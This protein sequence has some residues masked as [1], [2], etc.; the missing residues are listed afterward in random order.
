[1]R[2]FSEPINRNAEKLIQYLIIVMVLLFIIKSTSVVLFNSFSFDGGMNAQ[3]AHNLIKGMNNTETYL[4]M[5]V[6]D[7]RIQTGFPVILPVA[8][9][10][11]VF[12]EKFSSGL[13]VNGVYLVLLL[14]ALIYYLKFCLQINSLF[15]FIIAV[16]FYATPSLFDFGF[17]LYGE[18][19]AL[20][21]FIL[22]II[23]IY[24]YYDTTNKSFAFFSGLFLGFA[25][26]TKTV[27]IIALPAFAL[28]ALIH[29]LFRKSIRANVFQKTGIFIFGF[30]LPIGILEFYKL[31]SL[32]NEA[33]TRWWKDMSS[34]IL[35]QAG[36][37]K[38]FTDTSG[39]VIK[40]LA[41]LDL[42]SSYIGINKWILF[43]GLSFLAISY[44]MI[45]AKVILTIKFSETSD[46]MSEPANYSF[47]ILM[48]TTLSYFGWWLLITTTQKAWHRRIING[49]ILFEICLFV[50]FYLGYKFF[51]NKRVVSDLLSK[52]V[53]N[54]VIITIF[55][56]LFLI[57]SIIALARS[58]NIQISFKDSDA[59][60]AYVHAGNYIKNLPKEALVF[61]FGWWQAPIASFTSSRDFFDLYQFRSE[62]WEPAEKEAFL[63]VDTYAFEIDPGASRIILDQY[64]TK[65]IFTENDIY[66]YKLLDSK[67]Y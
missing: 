45:L 23:F 58:P 6:F 56:S 55:S 27:I 44:L 13:L 53:K 1:M 37:V 59:K 32:G 8:L 64:E 16:I 33:Y 12:G 49:T 4:G 40:F 63:V 9:N 18:I 65:L 36:V 51:L 29:Q 57:L 22:S 10:F 7:P 35:M 41:H 46:E 28:G 2:Y 66:V 3:A 47:I 5:S 24:K 14:A 26:L 30:L 67:Q 38:G 31:A 34:A 54:R 60:L 39:P 50:L 19:P 20:F 25:C 61:G 21:Y 15:I 43:A 42:L 17:G 11:L 52:L 62:G 48:T